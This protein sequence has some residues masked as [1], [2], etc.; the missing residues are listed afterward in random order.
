EAQRLLAAIVESQPAP[1]IYPDTGRMVLQDAYFRL[2]RLALAGHQPVAAAAHARRG[3][4]LGG[5]YDDLFVANLLVARG[6][7]HE[8]LGETREAL[9]DYDRAL[10]I[11]EILL[12]T[13]LSP[14]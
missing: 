10:R 7:A 8:A 3:L 13:T 1:G 6:A 9:A 5:G 14:P 4:A 11:N 2:A 12:Q